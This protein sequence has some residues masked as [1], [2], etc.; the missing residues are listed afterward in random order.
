VNQVY[1]GI[2]LL[3]KNKSILQLQKESIQAKLSNLET[4]EKL[5]VVLLKDVNVL[6]AEI[7]KIE[8]NL[9]ALSISIENS[10]K[11]LA[12]FTGDSY[13]EGT[14]FALPE[15]KVNLD[16]FENKRLE[17]S[18]LQLNTEKLGKTKNLIDTKSIPKVFGFGTAGYGLPGLNM[19]SNSFETFYIVGVNFSWKP[20]N[21]HKNK[22]EK[23]ILGLQQRII[24][25]QK[26]AF[27]QNLHIELETKL[28]EVRKYDDMLQKDRAI[29]Q[30]RSDIVAVSS[31][32]FDNGVITSAD[33]LQDLNAETQSKLNTELHKIQLIKAKLDYKSAQG[34]L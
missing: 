6:K 5:G 13:H 27:T 33:Y 31:S 1:L 22:K 29:S 34:N 18:I 8:Q 28:S 32:Q 17:I 23:S 26:D 3:K 10:L 19:F 12:I 15:P 7:L 16:A 11:S 24:T 2:Q 30:L 4:A 20:W 14:D 25:T 9:S 21:W